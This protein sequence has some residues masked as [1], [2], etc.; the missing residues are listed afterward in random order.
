MPEDK[1]D[2]HAEQ[3]QKNPEDETGWQKFKRISGKVWHF[4]WVED[5]LASWIANIIVAFVV[6]KFIVYPVLGWMLGTGYPIVAVVSGS[7]QHDGTF[8]DWWDRQC[9]YSDGSAATQG[10]IYERMN[11]T[12]TQF[13]DYSFKNGFNKGDLMI[14]YSA[15]DAKVGDVLVYTAPGFS[16]P[17]IHRIIYGNDV[18]VTKGDANCGQSPFERNIGKDRVLGKAI[19]R[20]PLLGWI[21]IG[22]VEIVMGTKCAINS[23]TQDCVVW[24]SLKRSQK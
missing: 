15:N 24:K 12:R 2:K 8:G 23:A 20:V 4:L 3:N 9:K 16:D 13:E 14:L 5:S 6:I 19:L 10:R 17:I 1:S 22:F 18:F 11:I 21:K 7:M